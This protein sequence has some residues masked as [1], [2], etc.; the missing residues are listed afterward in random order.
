MKKN[1]GIKIGDVEHKI[2]QF[3][4]DTTLI[5]NGSRASF[6]A[7]LDTLAFYAKISGLKMTAKT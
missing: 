3:A 2:S 5:L 6:G 4:D 7:A 1:K